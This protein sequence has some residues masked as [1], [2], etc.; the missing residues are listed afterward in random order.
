MKI[1]I[2]DSSTIINFAMNGIIDI[3]IKLKEVF[4]GKFII[5]Q[6]VKY[7]TIDRPR[8]IKK[9]E[10]GALKIKQL[11][12]QGVLEMP[13]AIGIPSPE[14]ERKTKEIMSFTNHAFSFEGQWMNIIHAGEASC[15]ALSMLASQKGIK[16]ALAIDERTTRMLCE[17]PENLHKLFESKMHTKIDYSEKNLA[18]FKNIKIIRSAELLYIAY[19]K[20]LTGTDNP[21]Y[22]DALLYG[23]KFKGCAISQEEIKEI[24]RMG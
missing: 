13:E 11:L 6:S 19:K 21:E 24:E 2:F 16:N 4:G 8:Q 5:T 1:I 23:V 14:I 12:E 17:K 9:F 18:Q 7:E 15:L 20:H 10:L 3:L 22:L